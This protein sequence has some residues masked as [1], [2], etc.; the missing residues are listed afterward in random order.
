MK[1]ITI[2]ITNTLYEAVIY[3]LEVSGSTLGLE[4]YS[5]A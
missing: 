3:M 1:L 4:T 5:P 2:N